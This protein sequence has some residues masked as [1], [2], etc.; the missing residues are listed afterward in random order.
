MSRAPLGS[1]TISDNWSPFSNDEKRFLF[2]VKSSPRSWDIYVFVITFWL[3]R[4][5]SLAR[6]PKLIPKFFK[7]Y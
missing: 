3:W 5:N 2:N 1:G 6:K 7:S 4:K